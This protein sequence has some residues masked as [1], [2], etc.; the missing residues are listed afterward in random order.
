MAAVEEV[1]KKNFHQTCNLTEISREKCSYISLDM[2][3]PGFLRTAH[4][5]ASEY[6][7]YDKLKY[8]V[9]NLKPIQVGLT[10]SDVSGHIPY[11]GAW[12]FNLSGFNVHKD[13]SSAE[14]VELLRRS[15]ID[16][17]KN[18]R[19]GVM[20]DDFARFFR[21]TFVF[22]GRKMNHSWVTF[23][24]MYDLAY[25]VKIITASPLPDT[26]FGF[27]SLIEL[28]FGRVFDVKAMAKKCTGLM[29]GEIGLVRMS[30]ILKIDTFCTKAHQAGH[31]SML[32]SKVF[33]VIKREY[34][35]NEGDYQ[36]KL[37]GI[38]SVLNASSQHNFIAPPLPNPI[39]MNFPLSPPLIWMPMPRMMGPEFHPLASGFDTYDGRFMGYYPC[40][41]GC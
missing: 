16:F 34:K 12:Q 30:R 19:E 5:D 17:D 28:F 35:L 24:G 36:G 11:H 4:R 14:L 21:R 31:D 27:L 33:S 25:M 22:G 32:T 9:D 8:N 20:L 37:Y 38:S 18:L 7:L 15:G 41:C 40:Y 13:P 3:F 39:F 10:L 1:W 2:E 6:E 23:H 29:G 26:L